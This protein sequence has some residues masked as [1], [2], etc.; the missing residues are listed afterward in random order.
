MPNYDFK[1]NVCGLV[2][3]KIMTISEYNEEQIC[4]SCGNTAKRIY[5]NVNLRQIISKVSKDPR[6]WIKHREKTK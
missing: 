5:N 2:E 4:N 3:N 1:C 6:D